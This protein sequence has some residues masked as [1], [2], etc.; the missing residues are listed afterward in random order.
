[1]SV[2]EKSI[3]SKIEWHV[4]NINS[5][6]H[7]IELEDGFKVCFGVKTVA[8]QHV[9]YLVSKSNQPSI[10]DI[11]EVLFTT[12]ALP[13]QRKR[14]YR[15]SNEGPNSVYSAEL[16]DLKTPLTFTCWISLKIM[17]TVTDYSHQL[18]DTL[19]A[20]QL[21]I[22]AKNGSLTDV[23]FQVGQSSKM[24][25]FTAHRSILSARS[26][27]F[28]GLFEKEEAA[29]SSV[30]IDDVQP[31]I[32]SHFLRFVY[33]GQLKASA[34]ASLGEL[35]ALADRYQIAT[36]QKL[37]RHP[38]QEMNASELT[39]LILSINC[40]PVS[41]KIETHTLF[42]K[43]FNNR[44]AH[45]SP[46]LIDS[47]S[48]NQTNNVSA[49]D[50]AN[51]F[52]GGNPLTPAASTNTSEFTFPKLKDTP[53]VSFN[54]NNRNSSSNGASPVIA[55]QDPSKF[56]NMGTTP[57][58]AC[59]IAKGKYPATSSTPST[60]GTSGV[61]SGSK[62][63]ASTGDSLPSKSAPNASN[64]SFKQPVDVDSVTLKAAVVA[65]AVS[66]IRMV[67]DE[68]LGSEEAS[69]SYYSPS[70]EHMAAPPPSPESN[71]S[72]KPMFQMSPPKL[73]VPNSS[74]FTAPSTGVC[75]TFPPATQ[76][77]R[78]G[79]IPM[80]SPASPLPWQPN[81][82]RGDGCIKIEIP[83][84]G[85]SAHL[86]KAASNNISS[87]TC[88]PVHREGTNT[89]SKSCETRKHLSPNAF[90]FPILHMPHP[91]RSE[92]GLCETSEKVISTKTL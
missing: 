58:S 80:R 44:L 63:S 42:G 24:K 53:S 27:V 86:L 22:S 81:A 21:W 39:S 13:D 25:T 52:F 69:H 40:T 85:S 73:V 54:F 56:N 15:V 72:I 48:N 5:K 12:C 29:S 3:T 78:F 17:E 79:K 4:T 37:C 49:L 83:P 9:I 84:L 55:L 92:D 47:N 60:S 68:I 76:E 26:P 7:E 20:E 34:M 30:V 36:L 70:R 14:M 64:F 74:S 35:Q 71:Y 28:A 18:A 89:H 88:S 87:P 31:V 77:G 57:A 67:F 46:L 38:L 51:Y 6:S 8:F 11:A 91:L 90:G 66:R 1:M 32:F 61:P 75:F 62:F 59:S 41:S 10:F 45:M 2:L 16:L 19:L 50:R 43:V 33:T 23:E 82:S 65:A